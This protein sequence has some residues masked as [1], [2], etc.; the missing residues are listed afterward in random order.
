[1]KEVESIMQGPLEP[2]LW[3]RWVD[4]DRTPRVIA[5]TKVGLKMQE[6]LEL[7]LRR[8]RGQRCRSPSSRC[9]DGGKIKDAG[10]P[11]AVA[12]A[13]AGLKMLEPLELL[14]R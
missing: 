7:L 4:D 1:V 13:E 8:R 3:W 11:Q 14:L 10:A 12:T 5:M 9:C 2:L 6:L